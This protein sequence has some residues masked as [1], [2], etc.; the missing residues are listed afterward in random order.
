MSSC[1]PD[2]KATN[3]VEDFEDGIDRLDVSDFGHDF[4]V[5]GVIANAVQDGDDTVITLSENETV[6]LS[7]FDLANLDEEDFIT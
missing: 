7:G 2:W 1:S 3:E 4:D 5:A 6:R